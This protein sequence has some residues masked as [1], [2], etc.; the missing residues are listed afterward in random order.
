MTPARTDPGLQESPAI[1]PLL[2]EIGWPNLVEIR[3]PTIGG[4]SGKGD[5]NPTSTRIRPSA[6]HLESTRIEV[7]CGLSAAGVEKS[8]WLLPVRRYAARHSSIGPTPATFPW[9]S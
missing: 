3:T 7:I 2:P 5:S 1:L 9:L 4:E 8:T 6:R